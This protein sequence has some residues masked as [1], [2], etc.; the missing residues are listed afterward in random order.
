LCSDTEELLPFFVF[1]VCLY[2]H[3]N[4]AIYMCKTKQADNED[5]VIKGSIFVD[6][7]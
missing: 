7:F 2:E 1:K 6:A 5:L 3:E 4:A